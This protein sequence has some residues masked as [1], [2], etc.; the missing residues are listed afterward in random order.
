[1]VAVGV[2]AVVVVV[3]VEEDDEEEDEFVEPDG[4][5][6]D[7][8]AELEPFLV[9]AP[10]AAVFLFVAC[11]ANGLCDL[12]VMRAWLGALFIAMT[13]GTPCGGA[14]LVMGFGVG[15]AGVELLE[16]L[17]RRIGTATIAT[18]SRPTIGHR[19]LSRR[20]PMMVRA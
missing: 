11:W 17:E 15:A 13:A 8:L 9:F 20:S 14:E 1:V 5:V 12:P 18:S 3:D 6:V 19:R 7:G 4:V 16:P 2:V 10:D